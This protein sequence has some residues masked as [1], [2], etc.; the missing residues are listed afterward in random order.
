VITNEPNAHL[1]FV[2]VLDDKNH[3]NYVF[4]IYSLLFDAVDAFVDPVCLMF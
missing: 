4:T 2:D 3:M 1:F